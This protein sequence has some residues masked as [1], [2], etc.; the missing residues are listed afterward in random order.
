MGTP[1]VDDMKNAGDPLWLNAKR[2]IIGTV[3][4]LGGRCDVV[5]IRQLL[6]AQMQQGQG[7]SESSP[8]VQLESLFEPTSKRDL[9]S[10]LFWG[11]SVV[12]CRRPEHIDQIAEA[13]NQVVPEVSKVLI[14]AVKAKG[15]ASLTDLQSALQSAGLGVE[16]ELDAQSALLGVLPR[17]P[18]L[19]YMPQLIFMKYVVDS[20][21]FADPAVQEATEGATDTVPAGD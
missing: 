13:D 16:E 21:T 14:E 8:E 17:I 11:Q 5:V 4:R 9:S 1:Q 7:E 3:M 6:A 15:T 12:R 18:E 19:F 2:Q 20:F 10:V